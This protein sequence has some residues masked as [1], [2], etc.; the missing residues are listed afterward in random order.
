MFQFGNLC[1]TVG[2]VGH[3]LL[4][5]VGGFKKGFVNLPTS[6]CVVHTGDV[7]QIR[8]PVDKFL[9]IALRRFVKSHLDCH[10][11]KYCVES[12]ILKSFWR[13]YKIHST[14]KRL[15]ALASSLTW[16]LIQYMNAE[17]SVHNRMVS[18]IEIYDRKITSINF[19][20]RS[21]L[22]YKSDSKEN[23]LSIVVE[24]LDAIRKVLN[25]HWSIGLSSFM[26]DT[27]FDLIFISEP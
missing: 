12:R 3:F 14:R 20:C 9:E 2:Q 6:Y 26:S 22:T 18:K 11:G 5:K 17:H 23:S 4:W 27:N 15:L 10:I 25:I 19:D 13:R 7:N 21:N 1:A 8:L 16:F 24:W